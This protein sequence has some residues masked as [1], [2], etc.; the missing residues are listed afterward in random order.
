MMLTITTVV[1]LSTQPVMML[2]YKY[3]WTL[4]LF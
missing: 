4:N 2:G 3:Q 1:K